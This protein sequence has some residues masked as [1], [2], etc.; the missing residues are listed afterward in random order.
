MKT[1]IAQDK[2][3]KTDAI[4]D[5]V[6]AD[7]SRR[8]SDNKPIHRSLPMEGKL[9][10]DRTLPFLCVYRRPQKR[11][12]Q[13]TEILVKSEAAY[14]AVS[15]GLKEKNGL[16][17]LVKGIVKTLAGQC[18][19]FLILEVW[20]GT[21]NRE[22]DQNHKSSL[23]P[24]FRIIMSKEHFPTKAV[25]AFEKALRRIKIHKYRA[26]VDLV[27]AAKQWPKGSAPFLTAAEADKF[28]CFTIGLE[29]E[30]IFRNPETG[31]VYPM[32]LRRL[33]QGL[34]RA[35][36]QGVF[37]FSHH[38]TSQ[39]PVN[40]Q[41]LGRRALVKTVWDID[42]RL[43][44]VGNAFDFLLQV[45]PI[46]IEQAWHKFRRN[47]FDRTPVFH[48]RPLPID[49]S[50]LKHKLYSS[51]VESVE[52]PTL[53]S[54]FREKQVELEGQ[55]SML[56]DRGTRNFLYG[57][58]QLFG[59]VSEELAALALL[60]LQRIPPHSRE[61]SG[62]KKLDAEAFAARAREEVTYYQEKYPG[63]LC[64]VQTRDDMVGLMVSRGNLFLGKHIQVPRSRVE[65]LLQHEVGTHAVTYF[66]GMAQPFHQLYIGLPGYDEL[67]EGLAVLAEYLVGGL[68]LPRLRLLA[69]RVLAT[70]DMISG[71]AFIDTF[72]RLNRHYGF[73]QRTAYII[74]ARI[75]RSGG[76][77]K[78]AVYLRGLV[79]VLKYLGEGGDLEP[80]F[81]GKIATNHVPVI[82]ELESRQV[83]KP[84]PLR[85]RYLDN[86]EA[87]KRLK[88]L[89][90][91]V[92]VLNLI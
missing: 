65:A 2:V 53:A 31:E 92:S 37:E 15:A 68:S 29:V 12:D 42:Q 89:A 33:H 88:G 70:R 14:L 7:V 20:T 44:E 84:I 39:R 82:K 30:P 23:K 80:L 24:R 28:N 19:A 91:D 8:L 35:I 83:L 6:I 32:V 27:F 5:R 21:E 79:R 16:P 75:Y 63:M 43:A 57:S 10:I 56:R 76:L 48:Y 62:G 46:N 51:P 4:S 74:T 67:Q 34:A 38:H 73:S 36:K 77:T 47:R 58:L 45:T 1:E 64:K 25:E 13:G 40:Y 78:D 52:D 87:G 41:A 60:M 54:L 69:G 66:N 90:R 11:P 50:R 81:V 71:A 18:K 3:K 72:R 26:E 22:N 61:S 55:L 49:P 86:P 59:G 85:P 17:A 9:H